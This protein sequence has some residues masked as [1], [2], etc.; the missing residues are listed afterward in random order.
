MA[1]TGRIALREVRRD[2]LG[3]LAAMTA[4]PDAVGEH[5]WSGEPVDAAQLQREMLARLDD[6]GMLGFERGTLVVEL[7][8]T[9]PIG[10]VSWRVE[11]WGPSL[12]SRC[13][14]FG[15][16]LLPRY[17]GRGYGTDAQRQLISYL[18]RTTDVHR[19]QSDTAL[20]N[21]AEQRALERIGMRREGTVRGAEFRGGRYH[22]HAL[23]GILRPEWDGDGP[24]GR[25]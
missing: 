22:D 19:I 23:Y 12:G 1:P 13:L 24:S 11:R 20:D 2:D 6:D 9:T 14:A 17:R 4:D 15:V 10:D 21:P 8:G 7:D 16:T 3:W 18:F 25:R 5:N